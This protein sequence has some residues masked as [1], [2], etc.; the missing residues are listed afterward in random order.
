M[1][2]LSQWRA[3]RSA[4]LRE[5]N[6]IEALEA[7]KWRKEATR[8]CRNCLT[9]YRIQMPGSGKYVCTY[10]GHISKRPVL[11]VAGA[12]ANPN[13]VTQ[14]PL[15]GGNGAGMLHLKGAWHGNGPLA[16]WCRAAERNR[17]AW[18]GEGSHETDK[19]SLGQSL[20][21]PFM[22]ISRILAFVWQRLLGIGQSNRDG[23]RDSN[24]VSENTDD[25]SRIRSEKARRKADKKKQ[26][27]LQK[28]MLEAEDRKQ[29]EEVALLVEERRRQRDQLEVT[30]QKEREADAERDKEARRKWDTEKLMEKAG[31]RIMP[32]GTDGPT[33]L[34]QEHEVAIQKSTGKVVRIATPMG[35]VKEQVGDSATT[36]T[37][38]STTT[39]TTIATSTTTTTRVSRG[40]LQDH[41]SRYRS[42]LGSF[43]RL[44]L[45]KG[46][47]SRPQKGSGSA[48]KISQGDG[49]YRGKK[50]AAHIGGKST[51][52][53]GSSNSSPKA[54]GTPHVPDSAWKRAPWISA[55]VK[56]SKGVTGDNS[57]MQSETITDGGIRLDQNFSSGFKSSNNHAFVS[58]SSSSP[59]SLMLLESALLA[60][61][62]W[63]I[64][65]FCTMIKCWCFVFSRLI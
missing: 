27:R 41:T 8:R 22:F 56:G 3:H 42:T 12:L 47:G 51:I 45:L 18:Y 55:W 65:E 32:R 19:C 50:D 30:N 63:A 11:E 35:I 61:Q 54:A 46:T 38:S 13:L 48:P 26:A 60:A 16:A 64:F 20:P 43:P 2:W 34:G 7:A 21:A 52:A 62:F 44:G 9:A 40:T 33:D 23:S 58:K 53:T 24:R 10:C 31:K 28:E 25:F 59:V 4:L 29:R 15:L 49:S 36:T 57:N 17:C 37:T 6:L 14:G 39:A 5:R 1:P